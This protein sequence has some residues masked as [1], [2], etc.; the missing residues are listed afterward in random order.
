[1]TAGTGDNASAQ[2]PPEPVPISALRH[3]RFCPRRC[4]LQYVEEVFVDN[5][6]T[7]EGDA[8]HEHVDDAGTEQHPDVRVVRGLPLF[9]DRLGL[10]GKAD[11]V[12]FHRQADGTE[13]PF[14]VEYKRGRRRPHDQSDVQVCAQ[15]ICLEE[16]L[17]V[18]VPA[19]AIYFGTSRRRRDVACDAALRRIVE[20][21]ARDVRALIAAGVTPSARLGPWCDG[22]SLRAAC[23]PEVTGGS[24]GSTAY[25]RGLSRAEEA[26][27]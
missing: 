26:A 6:F 11:V 23:M 21:T 15:A 9:S 24:D 12:E 4:A 16:M 17:G 22:C 14:P 5:A 27:R 8:L 20:D 1:V 3:Y 18:P 7:L 13:A 10:S 25:L 2:E 19:G